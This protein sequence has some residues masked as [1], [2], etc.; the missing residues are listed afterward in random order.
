MYSSAGYDTPIERKPDQVTIQSLM[1]SI[2][3]M[4]YM[5]KRHDGKLDSIFQSIDDIQTAMIENKPL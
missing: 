2:E 5:F 1:K 4:E 3:R